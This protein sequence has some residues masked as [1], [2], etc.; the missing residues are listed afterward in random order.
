MCNKGI[1]M[2]MLPKAISELTRKYLH[3]DL[4]I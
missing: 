4:N 3:G 1:W 2:V